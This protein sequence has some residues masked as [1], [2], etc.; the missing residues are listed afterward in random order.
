MRKIR[1]SKSSNLRSY[2]D[3]AKREKW[4]GKKKVII[5]N[6]YYNFEENF[7]YYLVLSQYLSLKKK[8]KKNPFQHISKDSIFFYEKQ[9]IH[10]NLK[11][12]RIVG[13]TGHTM[14]EKSGI[15]DVRH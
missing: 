13:K 7:R 3:C 14:T 11:V 4:E 6:Y 12:V 5:E 2:V 8:I 1:H 15:A 9:K 10:I